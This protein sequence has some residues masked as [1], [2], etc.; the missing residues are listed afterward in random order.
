MNDKE[1]WSQSLIHSFIESDDLLKNV[2]VLIRADIRTTKTPSESSA[3][4]ISSASAET[5]QILFQQ[6]DHVDPVAK[7]AHMSMSLNIQD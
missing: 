6:V 1:D 3:L 7:N 4:D 2:D 5:E